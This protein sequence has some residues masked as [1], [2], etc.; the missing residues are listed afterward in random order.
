MRIR[1]AVAAVA[2]T[3]VSAGSAV[4]VTGGSPASAATLKCTYSTTHHQSVSAKGTVSSYTLTK[5][6]CG[7]NYTEREQGTSHSRSGAHS[8]YWWT[9]IMHYPCW[10]K[11]GTRVS[12]TAK[13][14]RTVSVTHSGNC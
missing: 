7:R 3:V 10:T 11:N 4:A 8:S 12:F 5:S 13:G 9:K 6:G 1:T 2:I 14:T